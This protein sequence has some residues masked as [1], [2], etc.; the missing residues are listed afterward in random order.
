MIWDKVSGEGRWTNYK[1]TE[2]GEQ[3]LTENIKPKMVGKWCKVHKYKISNVKKRLCVCDVCKHEG[4]FVV[5]RD[6]IKGK[7]V[8][9]G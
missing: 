1:N 4:R 7:R 2:T 3:S 8:V 9:L 5:G 6:E